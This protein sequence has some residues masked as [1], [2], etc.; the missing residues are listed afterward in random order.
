MSSQRQESSCQKHA[1]QRQ[2]HSVLNKI[3]IF[4]MWFSDVCM[5]ERKM[6][7]LYTQCPILF[8]S[9]Q[10]ILLRAYSLD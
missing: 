2:K 4:S 8:V 7:C 9:C 10:C 1:E 5:R 6:K 3:F